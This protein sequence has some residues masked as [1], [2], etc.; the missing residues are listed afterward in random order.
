[1]KKNLFIC[2]LALIAMSIPQVVIAQ[3]SEDEILQCRSEQEVKDAKAS[4]VVYF[5]V[6]RYF[7]VR[8]GSEYKGPFR[9]FEQAKTLRNE[10]E[11]KAKQAGIDLAVFQAET[12][13]AIFNPRLITFPFVEFEAGTKMRFIAP[14]GQIVDA[15]RVMIHPEPLLFDDVSFGPIAL[16]EKGN[17]F[18]L[19]GVVA[20]RK[21]VRF[22]TGDLSLWIG[23]AVISDNGGVLWRDYGEVDETMGFTC[24]EEI[25]PT[26]AIPHFL[27]FFTVAKGKIPSM[28]TTV[29]D[30]DP[31]DTSSFDYHILCSALLETGPNW[32]P[33]MKEAFEEEYEK[34]VD[35]ERESTKEKL[36]RLKKK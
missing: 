33:P 4:G 7:Y 16:K 21:N 1:M 5:K 2:C 28:L 3:E 31:I 15:T 12:P 24:V 19:T 22:A 17:Y 30:A 35:E 11:L 8:I 20:A 26:P 9:T 34:L 32:F 10:F 25:D 36:E 23:A 27:L 6:G 29:K 14:D 13:G 18:A